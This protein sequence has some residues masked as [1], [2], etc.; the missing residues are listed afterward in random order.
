MT[1][2]K[3]H[4][5]SEVE[6]FDAFNKMMSC[7]DVDIKQTEDPSV[8]NIA[9]TVN[10][11]ALKIRLRLTLN[12]S[13]IESLQFSLNISCSCRITLDGVQVIYASDMSKAI[14]MYMGGKLST[15]LREGDKPAKEAAYKAFEKLI[16]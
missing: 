16:K 14:A 10:G 4:D 2:I 11:K 7:K 1:T 6:I 3:T 5:P 8:I 9:S 13:A 12:N 15:I